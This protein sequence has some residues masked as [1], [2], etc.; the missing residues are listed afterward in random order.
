MAVRTR[1][2][3]YAIVILL[4]AGWCNRNVSTVTALMAGAICHPATYSMTANTLHV[5]GGE[6]SVG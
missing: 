6:S 1:V 5:D 3:E 2:R 4:G